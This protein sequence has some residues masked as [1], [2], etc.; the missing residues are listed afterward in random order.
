MSKQKQAKEGNSG[1]N[2]KVEGIAALILSADWEG[3]SLEAAMNLLAE[4]RA[5]INKVELLLSKRASAE[6]PSS[7][8]CEQCS[9]DIPDGKWAHS[10]TRMNHATGLFVTA[11]F[12]SVACYLRHAQTRLPEGT[13]E[14][15]DAQPRGG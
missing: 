15:R 11:Y 2:S 3:L 14:V 10:R 12:C 1:D 6:R 13:T 5:A 9:K 4:L 8:P 7:F